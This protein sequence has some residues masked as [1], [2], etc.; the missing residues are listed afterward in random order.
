LVLT[1]LV[2][3]LFLLLSFCLVVPRF[4]VRSF[5]FDLRP[6]YEFIRSFCLL[7]IKRRFRN[8]IKTPLILLLLVC[9]LLVSVSQLSDLSSGRTM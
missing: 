8:Y 3:L 1:V 9:T 4:A 6:F 5:D 7:K 2:V